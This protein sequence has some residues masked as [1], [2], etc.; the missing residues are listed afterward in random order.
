MYTYV[1]VRNAYVRFLATTVK[2]FWANLKEKSKIFKLEVS[3][4]LK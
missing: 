1:D 3:R 4:S 2:N